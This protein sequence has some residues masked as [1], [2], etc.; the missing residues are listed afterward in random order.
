MTEF[1]FTVDATPVPQPRQRSRVI[2][3]GKCAFI[4]NYTPAKH[5]V[6]EFKRAVREAASNKFAKP[7]DGPLSMHV[8]FSIPA[9]KSDRKRANSV[10]AQKPDIDNLLK[11]VMDALS[12]VAWVDDSQVWMVRASKW[13]SSS[14]AVAVSI[15]CE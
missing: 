9:P 10:H 4:Q 12:G 7:L 15:E 2:G 13:W 11:A 14:G 8:T 3:K 5:P 1:Q 6:Q